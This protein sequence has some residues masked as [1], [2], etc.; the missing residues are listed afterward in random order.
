M[1]ELGLLIIAPFVLGFVGERFKDM[2]TW[3]YALIIFFLFFGVELYHSTSLNTKIFGDSFCN[4][5]YFIGL[6]VSAS[7]FHFQKY[8]RRKSKEG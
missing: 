8:L 3:R 6:V 4:I 7:I 2:Q 5:L 1:F